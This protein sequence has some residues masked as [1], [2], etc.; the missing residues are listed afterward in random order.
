[1]FVIVASSFSFKAHVEDGIKT[2][3]FHLRDL[4]MKKY[5]TMQKNQ[6][7]LLLPLHYTHILSS[8]LQS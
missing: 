2:A 8:H 3:F 7:M 6:V 1:M 5:V 4:A